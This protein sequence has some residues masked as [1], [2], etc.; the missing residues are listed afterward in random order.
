MVARLI[1]NGGS[2]SKSRGFAVSKIV[3]ACPRRLAISAEV[4]GRKAGAAKAFLYK[5][6]YL[7]AAA[8]GPGKNEAERV[9]Y[10][11]LRVWMAEPGS[12]LATGYQEK[13]GWKRWL[14][15]GAGLHRRA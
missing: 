13:A 7:S 2:K 15:L 9:S 11:N 14:A 5:N 6:L 3:R 1:R 8:R 4:E 12:S 10:A